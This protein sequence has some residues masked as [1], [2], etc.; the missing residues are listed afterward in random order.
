MPSDTVRATIAIHTGPGVK[1]KRIRAL[2][3]KNSWLNVIVTIT[4]FKISQAT[5]EKIL[6]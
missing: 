6:E 4:P 5:N 3:Y 1:N 2:A